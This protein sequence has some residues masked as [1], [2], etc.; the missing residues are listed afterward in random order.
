[1]TAGRRPGYVQVTVFAGPEIVRAAMGSTKFLYT[2]DPTEEFFNTVIHSSDD[3]L[4]VF[5]KLVE[6]QKSEHGYGN[7]PSAAHST[8]QHLFFP[9]L[10]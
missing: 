6:L 4:R 1:M 10:C 5:M 3:L 8:G 2:V 7:H 9:T